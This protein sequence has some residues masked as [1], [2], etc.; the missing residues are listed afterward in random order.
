MAATASEFKEPE[1]LVKEYT[2]NNYWKLDMLDTKELDDLLADYEWL[3][4]WCI[5]CALHYSKQQ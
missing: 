3:A 4:G 2:D 5:F 1:P